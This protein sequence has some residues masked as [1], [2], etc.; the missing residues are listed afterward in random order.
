M[1]YSEFQE[2]YKNNPQIAIHDRTIQSILTETV[3]FQANPNAALFLDPRNIVSNMGTDGLCISIYDTD[4]MLL[5]GIFDADSEGDY[6]YGDWKL[7]TGSKLDFSGLAP[8]RSY[9][10]R[11]MIAPQGNTLG[12]SPTPPIPSDP[13]PIHYS[14]VLPM[15]SDTDV[16]FVSGFDNLTGC[17]AVKII[18][19]PG[20]KY[21]IIN[22][23]DINIP[24]LNAKQREIWNIRVIGSDGKTLE[25]DEEGYWVIPQGI[26][27]IRMIVPAG[28]VYR[29]GGIN[30]D[31]TKFV[32]KN[33]AFIQSVDKNWSVEY[34]K[35]KDGT[36]GRRIVVDPAC[37]SCYYTV[38]WGKYAESYKVKLDPGKTRLYVPLDISVS[39]QFGV[40]AI[41]FSFDEMMN[42][43]MNG[44]M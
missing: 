22:T 8:D 29:F 21:T 10:I 1:L 25:P 35:R 6:R 28:G 31:G 24:P 42:N 4:S 3:L 44:P 7:G 37:P 16:A 12:I 34:L 41:P 26:E 39:G 17:G 36:M 30:A 32:S 27:W 11:T 14:E 33:L 23:D 19:V 9:A 18:P 13:L 40:V 20:C 43:Q 5:Y 15:L 38:R 2:M